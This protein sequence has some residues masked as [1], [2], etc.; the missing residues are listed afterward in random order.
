MLN[1]NMEL[2]N[3]A[4]EMD[5]LIKLRKEFDALCK[6]CDAAEDKLFVWDGVLI[7]QDKVNKMHTK[8]NFMITKIY[9]LQKTI[10]RGEK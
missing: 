7:G 9:K 6:K 4:N 5:K 2:N 1:I 8:L 3:M 10:Q